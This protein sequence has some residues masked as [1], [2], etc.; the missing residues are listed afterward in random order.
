MKAKLIDGVLSVA[1]VDQL[2]AAGETRM[3]DYRN[4][5]ADP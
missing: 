2:T 4:E 5:Q 3:Y 1:Y